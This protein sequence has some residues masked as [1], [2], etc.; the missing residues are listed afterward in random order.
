MNGIL[1]L[2]FM[3]F[4]RRIKRNS[5][6]KDY[7]SRFAMDYSHFSILVNL[8]WFTFKVNPCS[9]FFATSGK[10]GSRTKL[11]IYKHVSGKSRKFLSVGHSGNLFVICSASTA[12][13]SLFLI[14]KTLFGQ[15]ETL[16]CTVRLR[17]C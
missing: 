11:T 10:K 17:F 7:F 16:S 8:F 9:H 14:F 4:F 6:S 5:M 13:R 15:V 2:L 12:F 1:K 3:L